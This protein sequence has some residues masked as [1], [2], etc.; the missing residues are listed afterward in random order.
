MAWGFWTQLFGPADGLGRFTVEVAVTPGVN[1]SVT[2][3]ELANGQ[4]WYDVSSIDAASYNGRTP[5]VSRNGNTVTWTWGSGDPTA[6]PAVPGILT[7][8]TF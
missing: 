8:G 6:P 1:G 2:N 3:P 5:T 4:F 7:L